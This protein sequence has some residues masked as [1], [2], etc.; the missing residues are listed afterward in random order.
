VARV[1][2]V[3]VAVFGDTAAVADAQSP[4]RGSSTWFAP[5]DGPDVV[6]F[7]LGRPGMA[8]VFH[9]KRSVAWS[10]S[11][12]W[13]DGFGPVAGDHAMGC[14]RGGLTPDRRDV[15]PLGV[16]RARMARCFT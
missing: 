6:L 10:G 1:V 7:G 12:R 4:R 5:A 16:R 3:I 9:V 14:R 2:V 13:R 15:A 11:G 8:R